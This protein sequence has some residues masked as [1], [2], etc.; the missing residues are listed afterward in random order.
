MH[1]ATTEEQAEIFKN[2]WKLQVLAFLS[3]NIVLISIKIA[4]KIL[5]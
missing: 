3:L 1:L 4:L 5:G 2:A